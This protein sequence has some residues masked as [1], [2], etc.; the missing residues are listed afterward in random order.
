MHLC[1]QLSLNLFKYNELFV[2][3]IMKVFPQKAFDYRQNVNFVKP[4]LFHVNI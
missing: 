1:Q 3:K 2:F 4:N